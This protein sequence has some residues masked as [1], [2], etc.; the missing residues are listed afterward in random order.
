MKSAY[1]DHV[2]GLLT[3]ATK[4][5]NLAR[6]IGDWETADR[7]GALAEE[8]DQRARGLARWDEHRIRI[9]ARQIWKRTDGR[10]SR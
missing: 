2:I 3:K 4:Y 8:L 9:R 6:G 1:L 10:L 7:I 5:R